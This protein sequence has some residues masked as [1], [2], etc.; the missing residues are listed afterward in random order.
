MPIKLAN[1]VGPVW[2]RGIGKASHIEDMRRDTHAPKEGARVGIG[3]KM[4]IS[5]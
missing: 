2:K 1:R 3:I 4:N 5:L